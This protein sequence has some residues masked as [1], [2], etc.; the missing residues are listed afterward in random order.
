MFLTGAALT[1]R[2]ETLAWWRMDGQSG[3]S[4]DGKTVESE[5]NSAAVNG[6][7]K[8]ESTRKMEYCS[9]TPD[10]FIYD[11]ISRTSQ[12]NLSSLFVR[13][14]GTNSCY[15][16]VPFNPA[17]NNLSGFTVEMFVKAAAEQ[18]TKAGDI[19]PVFKKTRLDDKAATFEI[20]I[21]RS[22]V[23]HSYNW[24]QA[25]VSVPGHETQELEQNRYDGPT[26]IT[27]GKAW[28]HIALTYD[29]TSSRVEFYCDYELLATVV[30]PVPIAPLDAGPILIGGQPNG[31]GITGMIDEVRVT[32]RPLEAWEFLRATPRAIKDVSF[33]P[34]AKPSLPN[35]SGYIDVKLRY[36]AIGDG[37]T[38]DTKA[39]R[40]AFKECADKVPT[41]YN[42]VYFPSGTYI[43]SDSCQWSRFMTI[44]GEGTNRTII[45]LKDDCPGFGHNAKSP[46][47]VIIASNWNGGEGSGSA[48]QN[49]ISD[50]TIDTGKGNTNAI[51]IEFQAN[52]SGGIENVLVRSGDGDGAV[53]LDFTRPWPGPCLQR[54]IRIEGFDVGIKTIHREYSLVFENIDLVD[55]KEAGILNEGNSLSIRKLASSG[56]APAIVN[57]NPAGL[58]V[59]LDGEFDGGSADNCAI[60]NKGSLYARNIKTSGYKAAIRT[61]GK[62]IAGSSVAEYMTAKPQMLFDSPRTSLNLPVEETPTPPLE[63]PSAWL[64]VACFKDKVKDGDWSDAIQAAFD[65]GKTTLYFPANIRCEIRKTIHVRGNVRRIVGLNS[66]LYGNPDIFKNMPILAFDASNN[67]VVVMERVAI[68]TDYGKRAWAIEHAGPQ[69][70]VLKHCDISGYRATPEAGSLFI[71][72]MSAGPWIFGHGQKIWARQL[73]VEG[74]NPVV[75]IV[76]NGAELWILGFNAQGAGLNIMNNNGAKTEILGGLIYPTED[77]PEGMPMFENSNAVFSAVMNES[78]YLKNYT[79]IVKDTQGGRTMNFSIKDADWPGGRVNI[80]YVSNPARKWQLDTNKE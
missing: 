44:Q 48:M 46:K 61:N 1:A 13:D 71:D 12:T 21:N 8:Q 19:L 7:A 4:A 50:L 10:D 18:L 41:A 67:A 9:D 31:R 47:A 51:G 17:S 22:D 43:V 11:P 28:H 56:P 73:N 42:T 25:S 79:F 26:H 63:D 49:Y 20:H 27:D 23:P 62:V 37:V 57:G 2:C 38:D 59:L 40:K 60:E 39:I 75:K 70:L 30:T 74:G 6:R 55:Q 33:K 36:G 32:K 45:K 29:A 77:V 72:D 5:T 53:G 76:N 80:N 54:N 3:V 69:T 14:N 58:V 15:V 78:S 16:Q 68:D 66:G 35:D 34:S 64:N 24:W 65:F 52:D